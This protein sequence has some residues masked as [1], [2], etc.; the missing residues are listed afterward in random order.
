MKIGISGGSGIEKEI[1]KAFQDF[2]VLVNGS[3]YNLKEEKFD[4]ISNVEFFP[5]FLNHNYIEEFGRNCDVYLDFSP[6]NKIKYLVSDFAT[7]FDKICYILLYDE[8]WKLL[9]LSGKNSHLSCYKKY[10]ISLPFISLPKINIDSLMSI[11]NEVKQNLNIKENWIY[12]LNSKEKKFLD[13]T[14]KI[15]HNF[16]FLKGQFA[17]IASVSCSDNSVAI[18]Q[19]NSIEINLTYYKEKLSKFLKL[20]RETPFFIEFKYERFKI[21]IFK[22]GRFIIKGTKEK[23]TAFYFFYHFFGF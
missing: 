8:S 7:Y 13:F 4:I 14:E 2:P 1:I 12:D 11:L 21:L 9:K 23:N 3:S 19:M 5:E 6:A 15:E 22:Q 18:S 16:D 10:S 20:T 17:D